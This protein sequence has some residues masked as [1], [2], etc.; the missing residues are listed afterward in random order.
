MAR[1]DTVVFISIKPTCGDYAHFPAVFT[2][3][4]KH[5][6]DFF[7]FPTEDEVNYR[8]SCLKTAEN[9]CTESCEAEDIKSVSHKYFHTIFFFFVI[10]NK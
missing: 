8:R 7:F 5:R 1:Q 9:E 6:Q 2:I 3:V 4:L 10:A